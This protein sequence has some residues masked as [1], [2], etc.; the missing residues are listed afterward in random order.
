MKLKLRKLNELAELICHFE[1]NSTMI[2]I[3]CFNG[4]STDQFLSSGKISEIY[5]VDPW[6]NNYD[7]GDPAS[8]A[9][10]SDAEMHFDM[11]LE[12]HK[13]EVT[14]HKIKLKSDEAF[15][16]LSAL[17]VDVVYIDGLH[18]YEGVKNDCLLYSKLVKPNGLLC[19]HDYGNIVHP[20]VKQAID[21]LYGKPELVF[22]EMSWLKRMP[23]VAD[24]RNIKIFIY[25]NLID[26]PIIKA[27]NTK[28]ANANRLHQHLE[29]LDDF[30]T[31]F[32]KYETYNA[33]EADYF[34]IPLFL[35][36]WQFVNHNPI[37][38]VNSCPHLHRG[39]HILLATGD[40]GQ[41]SE[42]RHEM[43][44][45]N[46]A[47]EKKYAWLD[48]RFILLALE[49]TTLLYKQD[50]AFLPYSTNEIETQNIAR[51]ILISFMGA[52]SYPQLDKDHI[53][54]GRLS[55]FIKNNNNKNIVV[56]TLDMVK[57][58]LGPD[59][60]YHNLMSRSFFT[61]CPAGYGRW[62]FR[63]IEA[64]LNGSIPIL[65]SDDYCIPFSD[66][67]NWSDYC[68]VVPESKLEALD[69]IVGAI[70]FSEI[71]AKLNNI[72]RD[73]Y[74]FEKEYTFNAV[75]SIL[76]KSVFEKKSKTAACIAINSMRSPFEMGI[77]CVDVTNKC[78][79]ACSNCTRLLANQ[80]E[81]WEMSPENF[82][83]ALQ[84]LCN[85]TGII[86]MIGGN[87]CLH[88]RFE[89]LCKIFVEEVPNRH[90]RGI[91]TNNVFGYSTTIET[92][93]G[94]F[95]LN[96]HNNPRAVEPLRAL[97]EKMVVQQNCGGGYYSGNSEH[98]PILTAVKDVYADVAQMWDAISKCDINQEWSASIVQNKGQLRVYFCEVAA[99]FDLARNED[100]GYPIFMDWWKHSIQLFAHQVRKFCP[101]CGVP[102]RLK[103]SWDY[104]GL[105]TYT[106]SNED[107]AVKSNIKRKR[108][109]FLLNSDS[110]AALG[111]KFTK[112]SENAR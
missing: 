53:R 73:R 32:K 24:Q 45:P 75:I 100:N 23:K 63:F 13:N 43:K 82:R 35:A 90:Q 34:F 58:I 64:L 50:I 84:S 111:H 91:W 89:E 74:K 25:R 55:E 87:P 46:R 44:I 17:R 52:I 92:T 99:S 83:T 79:L 80:D 12:K 104:E 49:S 102:A 61:L 42:S 86:A 16:Y 101:G 72:R 56:G 112:Y 47:Y 85:Y 98:A 3:G 10:M 107:I 6:E 31:L 20:G 71:F 39:N 93:F 8:C 67:I 96:P 48:N 26:N 105:D 4:E 22:S 68:I 78:D 2:E 70:P 7:A 27:H 103:G 9:D 29:Y 76:E 95:N 110:N 77:I 30:Y 33:D 14:I 59:V 62:S 40:F 37:D 41:R 5:C 36:G 66:T 57:D 81:F 18:T 88:S 109:I 15:A 11:V 28:L 94:A 1:E 60:T 21:E 38:L 106:Q 54:G 69:E 19:G 51:D 108:K 65:M 97:Y